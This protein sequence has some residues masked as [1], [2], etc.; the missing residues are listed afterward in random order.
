MISFHFF[1]EI[2]RFAWHSII[3]NKL[4]TFLSLLGVTIG[5]LAV[6]SVFTIIDSLEKNVRDSINRL[7]SDVIYIQKWPWGNSDAGDY[8]WWD[9]M[10]RPEVEIGEMNKLIAKSR[11]AEAIAFMISAKRTL[12]YL[13][14]SIE[15]VSVMAVSYQ[16]KSIRSFDLASGR[17]FTEQ[18]VDGAKNYVILG[19]TIALSLLNNLDN[20]GEVIKIKGE[21]ATVIGVFSKE[22]EDITGNSLDDAVVVPVS[23]GYKLM[24]KRWSNPAIIAK[25]NNDVSNDELSNELTGIMRSLRRLKPKMPDNFAMNEI[26]LISS[27]LD[28]VFSIIDLAGWIVGGFSILVGGFGIANI[29][30]VSVK[31]RTKQIGIQKSLG[32]KNSFILYQFLFESIFLCLIGGILGLTLVFILTQFVSNL[33]DFSIDL[34]LENIAL[35]LSVSIIIGI[36]SGIVPALSASKLDPVE[37]IRR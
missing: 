28:S 10:S 6:I 18:E 17:Y 33:F 7:G 26:S 11:K 35:G 24:N 31:E 34:T 25:A 5:I 8:K 1:L 22:G 12:K 3:S 32:A 36:I 13:N 20:V 16:W 21:K 14:N 30:F 29:M 9:F 23:F 37:A 15:G 2:F 4:R 19:H 27:Q